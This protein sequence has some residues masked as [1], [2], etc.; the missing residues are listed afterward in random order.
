MWL[1]LKSHSASTHCSLLFQPQ[2]A[3]WLVLPF[4]IEVTRCFP[5]ITF[6]AAQESMW[7]DLASSLVC[8]ST[9]LNSAGP[10]AAL[11]GVFVIQ[12][13]QELVCYCFGRRG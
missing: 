11:E 7:C 4:C 10:S 1:S 12:S 6:V 9:P 5:H 2:F 13:Q 8:E 3:T